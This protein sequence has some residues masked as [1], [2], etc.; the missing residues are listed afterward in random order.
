MD[1]DSLLILTGIFSIPLIYL[2]RKIINYASGTIQERL[3][4]ELDDDLKLLAQIPK[5]NYITL[6]SSDQWLVDDYLDQ[7]KEMKVKYSKDQ[8]DHLWENISEGSEKN[9]LRVKRY[10]IKKRL[11]NMG[12]TN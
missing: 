7:L 12:L 6:A 8:L 2:E 10:R 3:N 11:E 9:Q 1:I 4:D 5:G